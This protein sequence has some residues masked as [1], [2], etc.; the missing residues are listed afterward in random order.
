MRSSAAAT[1]AA[2][3]TGGV[4]YG[5]G[6]GVVLVSPER[7]VLRRGD[8]AAMVGTA[9]AAVNNSSGNSSANNSHGARLSLINPQQ[10]GNTASAFVAPVPTTTGA[11][12]G[13]SS[14][15]KLSP[16]VSPL[17]SPALGPSPQSAAATKTTAGASAGAAA[18]VPVVPLVRPRPGRGYSGNP[19]L[20][21]Q[22]PPATADTAP[23]T[24]ASSISTGGALSPI[25]ER[26]RSHTAKTSS[27]SAGSA[28][29]STA[30]TAAASAAA[31]A[32][33]SSI[34][35]IASV[36]S[37]TESEPRSDVKDGPAEKVQQHTDTDQ[38]GKAAVYGARKRD[39]DDDDEEEDEEEEDEE[40]PKVDLDP[41]RREATVLVSG[42]IASGS[43]GANAATVAVASSLTAELRLAGSLPESGDSDQLQS[44]QGNPTNPI[45]SLLP[46][47]SASTSGK[48]TAAG[49]MKCVSFSLTNETLQPDNTTRS[50]STI[51]DILP[52]S[53]NHAAQLQLSTAGAAVS[54]VS[55][56]GGG[57]GGGGGGVGV[58]IP[59]VD[60]VVNAPTATAANP[61]GVGSD[62]TSTFRPNMYTEMTHM[63]NSYA[64]SLSHSFNTGSRM[65][66]RSGLSQQAIAAEAM[67]RADIDPSR[68]A[69]S[70]TSAAAVSASVSASA[71]GTR[72]A[73]G[74]GEDGG[75]GGAADSVEDTAAGT[76][77]GNMHDLQHELSEKA[78]VVIRRVMDK[79]T[80]LDFNPA[81]QQQQQQQQREREDARLPQLRMLQQQ[82]LGA[83]TVQPE[84]VGSVGS[85]AVA[86]DVPAQVD[87][88]INQATSSE[89][90]SLSFFGWCPFW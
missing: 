44:T 32:A 82:V 49:S 19:S 47:D 33:N 35:K 42:D 71:S 58:A 64:H 4:E 20:S 51:V 28:V 39:E 48:M 18:A 59:S 5:G 43:T 3:S 11:G 46:V 27:A 15:A 21:L 60:I 23:S 25:P 55:E 63:A 12:T 74:H 45:T 17:K 86:L 75:G 73:A 2:A 65:S 24:T 13:A 77:H 88:L 1:A 37:S 14:S 31:A 26:R 62:H 22:R 16:D 40:K 30:G 34:A 9:G 52:P 36:S 8:A 10:A 29:P 41:S 89:N 61:V 69:T 80:G 6:G 68:S 54:A 90:L 81:T 84:G 79:L 76:G 70:D 85:A 83:A 78:V 50:T 57:R 56:E 87:R 7:P 66:L 72:T 53:S 67:M 38:A